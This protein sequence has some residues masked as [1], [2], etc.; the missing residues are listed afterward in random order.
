M[1]AQPTSSITETE[2]KEDPTLHG[3]C[4]RSGQKDFQKQAVH[5]SPTNTHKQRLITP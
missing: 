2:P 3:W 1:E 5:L 4:V